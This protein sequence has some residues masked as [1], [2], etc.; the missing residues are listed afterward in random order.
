MASGY[1]N[2]SF[3]PTSE[4]F[5]G[6]RWSIRSLAAA[7]LIISCRQCTNVSDP[8]SLFQEGENLLNTGD[9]V[10]AY[11]AFAKAADRCSDNA[12]YQWAA[13]S[14][15][16]DRNKQYIHTVHAWDAG[17]KTVS[18]FRSYLATSFHT[19][20]N[21]K[22]Q[23]AFSLY[24]ELPDTIQT[25]ALKG[26]VFAVLGYH[27]SALSCWKSDLPNN[28]R[29]VYDVAV[30]YQHLGHLDS[31]VS[32]LTKYK[33]KD[34]LGI[35]GYSL[36]AGLLSLDYRFDDAVELY[37]ELENR[38]KGGDEVRLEHAGILAAQRSFPAALRILY[39]LLE[40]DDESIKARASLVAATIFEQTR[41]RIEL[42]K[43]AEKCPVSIRKL[44][45]SV[46]SPSDKTNHDLE[47]NPQG[48]LRFPHAL[49]LQAEILSTTGQHQAAV[50]LYRL[51]P[52]YLLSSPLLCP[53]YAEELSHTGREDLALVVLGHMH[54]HGVSTRESLILFRDI[55]LR[56]GFLQKGYQAQRALEALT[57]MEPESGIAGVMVRLRLGKLREALKLSQDL[58]DRFPENSPARATKVNV[59]YRM[60]E[61][62][63]VVEYAESLWLTH[64]SVAVILANSLDYEGNHARAREIFELSIQKHASHRAGI[65]LERA[66][67]LVSRGIHAE[68]S[69]LFE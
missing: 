15:A 3:H 34:R 67:Y 47:G 8:S 22:L 45:L 51:I 18:V 39:S 66:S 19:T 44:L 25:Q 23:F 17:R 14:I 2:R 46:V 26:E 16:P 36:L 28:P 54:E 59:L 20:R 68:A 12:S 60:K 31:A 69:C 29:L 24:D 43:L 42:L 50:D 7:L 41:N 35:E 5:Q 11:S 1:A 57:V 38:G 37:A 48:L 4:K 9:T 65:Q 6:F 21:E 53:G 40:S 49:L 62:R 33:D 10:R 13:A 32:L 56:N 64:P 30:A 27:D 63:K 61:Y 52:G 58:I 55:C